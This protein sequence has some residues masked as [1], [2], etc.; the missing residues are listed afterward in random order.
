[1]LAGEEC[2]GF[3]RFRPLGIGILR[4]VH[5]LAVELGRLLAISRRIRGTGNAQ[6]GA[7]AVGGLLERRL[8]FVQGGS[9]LARFQRGVPQATPVHRAG[10]MDR[11]RMSVSAYLPCVDN[12]CTSS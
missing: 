12:K 6:E 3:L 9:R 1:M 2:L 5:E 8:E 10:L 11:A 4:Q 7:V